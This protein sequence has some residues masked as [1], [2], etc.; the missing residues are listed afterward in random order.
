VSPREQREHLLEER[1]E[2][3]PIALVLHEA[4]RERLPQHLALQACRRH[5]V[6]G[7]EALRDRDLHAASPQRLD[8]VEDARAHPRL[9]AAQT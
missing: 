4:R 2:G 3:G 5:G 6:H 8:E 1:V 7:V 9:L